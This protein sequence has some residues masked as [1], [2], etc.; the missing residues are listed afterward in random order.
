VKS[1]GPLVGE[2]LGRKSDQPRSRAAPWPSPGRSRDVRAGQNVFSALESPST[3]RAGKSGQGKAE[4]RGAG[5]GKATSEPES[6]CRG[7]F[8]G[9]PHLDRLYF[10][11]DRKNGGRVLRRPK[12]ITA[13][14]AWRGPGRGKGLGKTSQRRRDDHVQSMRRFLGG[15]WLLRPWSWRQHQE[16]DDPDPR[17]TG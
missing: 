16:G 7:R 2:D 9:V 10:K 3:K 15:A 6:L 1:D 17:P 14:P 11:E 12:G 8:A 4:A 13:P 5:E